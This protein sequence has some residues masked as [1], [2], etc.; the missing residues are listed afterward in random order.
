MPT[1]IPDL[2]DRPPPLYRAIVGAMQTDILAGRLVPGTRLPTHRDLAWALGVTRG[3]VARAYDEAERLGLVRGEVGRGTV[4]CDP[5]RN[6]RSMAVLYEAESG[7]APLIDMTLNRPSG[8]SNAAVVAA[9]LHRLADRADLPEVLGYRLDESSSRYAAAG[10]AWLRSRGVDAAPERTVMTAGGQQA[11][12]AIIAALTRPGDAI[13]C[14]EFVYPGFRSA[15]AVLE[16]QLVPVRMDAHGLCPEALDRALGSRGPRMICT[17]PDAHNPTTITQPLERREAISA[18]ARRHDAVIVED[19]AYA[20]LADGTP[21]LSALAPERTIH[22]TSLA[23]VL[24]PALRIGFVAGPKHVTGRIAAGVAATLLMTPTICA[25]V[26]AALIE[27]GTAAACAESQR[28]EAAARR[29]LAAEILGEDSVRSAAL[30]NA[31]LTIPPPRDAAG[32]AAEA[33]RRGVVVTPGAACTVRQ[34]SHQ[35]VRVSIS[36]PA[37]RATLAA[38][39]RVLADLRSGTP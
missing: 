3:T 10:A 35:A 16:R 19:G 18:V 6:P 34:P 1:W 12:V 36:A 31:W 27:D 25:E 26:V 29:R 32:F 20:F 22:V 30:F 13:L 2:A 15:A 23:W 24:A 28:A 38:G 21:P 33:R 8:D 4:V 5:A 7:A 9:A 17:M 14:E 39:L 11:F 37:D